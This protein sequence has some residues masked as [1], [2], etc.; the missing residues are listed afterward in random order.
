M[1]ELT[2]SEREK[3]DNRG[4][5]LVTMAERRFNFK[6]RYNTSDKLYYVYHGEGETDYWYIETISQLKGFLIGAFTF[7]Y[8]I[9]TINE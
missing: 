1:R 7:Q 2:I 6:I 9:K 4:M 5:D 3:L 8:G